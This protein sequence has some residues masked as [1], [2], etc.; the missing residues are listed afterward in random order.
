MAD[1][2]TLALHFHV[3]PKVIR[4]ILGEVVKLMRPVHEA[5]YFNRKLQRIVQICRRGVE[6]CWRRIE[7]IGAVLSGDIT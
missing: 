2:L 7:E 1:R 3:T 4:N 5:I 6:T